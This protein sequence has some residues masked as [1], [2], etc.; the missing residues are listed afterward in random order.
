MPW[1]PLAGGYYAPPACGAPVG[2]VVTAARVVA[3]LLPPAVPLAVGRAPAR[4]SVVQVSGPG[5]RG[6]CCWVRPPPRPARGLAA[7]RPRTLYCVRAC[8]PLR[9]LL[10]AHSASPPCAGAP[11]PARGRFGAAR[12]PPW[13]RPFPPAPSL[14]PCAPLSRLPG[15]LLAPLCFGLAL[16]ALRPPCPVGFAPRRARLG[17]FAGSPP[18]PPLAVRLLAFVPRPGFAAARLQARWL[19]PGGCGRLAPP[20]F[21]PRP[22]ALSAARAAA[23]RLLGPVRLPFLRFRAAR[24]SLRSPWR[25]A[26]V[27]AVGFS[28]TI[29]PA[30]VGPAGASRGARGLRPSGC[31][32]GGCRCCGGGLRKLRPLSAGSL[33]A[34]AQP[35]AYRGGAE[36]VLDILEQMC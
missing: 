8:R 14:G 35:T 34:V 16:A 26:A 22:R 33:C 11:A 3:D 28:P 7:Q 36:L 21:S 17:R 5:P 29:P 1:S 2:A 4:L 31:A 24:A 27:V 9:G 23:P 18:G 6:A 15:R 30:P 13:P 19:P 10:F 20:F 32:A 25:A 12:P